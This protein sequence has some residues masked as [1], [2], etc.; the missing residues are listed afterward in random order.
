MRRWTAKEA[1]AA[2]AE[3][4]PTSLETLCPPG[5]ILVV[6]PHPDDETLGCGGLIARGA[7]AGRE[8]VVAILTDGAASHPGSLR[9]PPHSM[10]NIRRREAREAV[11]TL[12]GGRARLAFFDAPDGGLAERE[13]QAV[14]WLRDLMAASSVG[15]VFASWSADHHPD[16]K[17]AFRIAQDYAAGSSAAFRAYPVWG[18]ILPDD[19][20]AGPAARCL[21][22]DIGEVVDRKR[23]AIAAHRS[24]TTGLIP[25]SREA[26]RLSAQDL[27]RHLNPVEPFFVWD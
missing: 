20:D 10:S 26:F 5:A 25:D 3:A 12:S 1:R 21:A 11:S 18:L 19:A 2:V 23:R 16:H 4:S 13:D 15:S 27:E 14:C 6:A 9:A 22:L 17:A 7:T 24:Q 8:V